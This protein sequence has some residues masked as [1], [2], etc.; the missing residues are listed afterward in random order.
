MPRKEY[1]DKNREKLLKW[2]R[3][4][5]KKN[6]DHVNYLKKL[7]RLK[8]LKK[9][10]QCKRNWVLKNRAKVNKHANEYKKLHPE[11]QKARMALFTAQ[12]Y[13]RI[14]KPKI[15]QGC[16]KK[17]ELEG[18]HEDYSKPLE[19]VWLCIKCHAKLHADKLSK[20]E[21]K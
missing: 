12:Q 1:R 8:N 15:C 11:K 18:H 19:V 6:R 20:G 16:F 13:G 5:R 10:K 14:I 2:D 9:D 21:V 17:K 7:W 4:W 3:E